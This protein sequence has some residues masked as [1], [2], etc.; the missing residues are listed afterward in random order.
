MSGTIHE[1]RL[2]IIW[3]TV[4]RD[5][6]NVS[7]DT[8]IDFNLLQFFESQQIRMDRSFKSPH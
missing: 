2:L 7:K 8:L 6:Q 5:G 4:T 3:N 1:D